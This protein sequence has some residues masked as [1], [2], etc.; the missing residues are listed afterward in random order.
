MEVLEKLDIADV[1]KNKDLKEGRLHDILEAI[2][3]VNSKLELN[4]VLKQV[5]H[6]AVR[7]TNSTAASII[8]KSDTNDDY[9]IA[10]SI[11]QTSGL[12]TN[13]RFPKTKGIAGA[14]IS[15]GQIKVVHDVKDNPEHFEKIDVT[16]GFKTKSILCVP[17][18]I[19]DNIIGCIELLNKSDGTTFNDDDIVIVTI[20]SNLAAISIRNV[21]TYERLQN[22][23]RCPGIT[24]APVKHTGWEK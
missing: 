18:S 5:I 6:Y 13:I 22:I 2:A 20:M 9:V 1:I 10:Y 12:V 19:K 3:V 4:Y 21:R 11:G 14:C 24:T 8:L 23:N 7:L 16:T 15:T 17:L